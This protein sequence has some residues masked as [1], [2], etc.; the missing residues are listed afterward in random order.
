V[1]QQ[2]LLDALA[3]ERFGERYDA[4]S[5]IVRFQRPQVLRPHLAG[6]ALER[7]NDPHVAFFLRRNPGHAR[8]D[9]LACLCELDET[10]L[11]RAGRRMVFGPKSRETPEMREPQPPRD[12][13]RS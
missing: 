13:R 4:A 5:G 3:G 8:G 7:M 12:A 2:R 1:D 6:V 10:N 11:T 9:E